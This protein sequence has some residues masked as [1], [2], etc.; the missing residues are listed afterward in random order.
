MNNDHVTSEIHNII[1]QLILLRN[2]TSEHVLK[3]IIDDLKY[4]QRSIE[5]SSLDSSDIPR[6][7]SLGLKV[8]KEIE[9]YDLPLSEKIYSL[10][11]TIIKIAGS[12]MTPPKKHKTLLPLGLILLVGGFAINTTFVFFEVHGLVRELT[13]LTTIVGLLLTLAGI[14]QVLFFMIRSFF[15]K[16]SNDQPD[17]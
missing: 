5:T 8:V 16:K 1:H 11:Q 6:A 9:D 14:G 13:R 15:K 12:S 17:V 10:V 7:E 2:K 3:N 4:F